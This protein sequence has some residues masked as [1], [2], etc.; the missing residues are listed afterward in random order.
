MS[1]VDK[2]IAALIKSQDYQLWQIVPNL[3]E[4]II[5]IFSETIEAYITCLCDQISRLNIPIS[6]AGL[7]IVYTPMH[8]V[9]LEVVK[10]IA[11]K[12]GIGNL[13][14]VPSQETPDPN[15]PTVK[16]PN[17]EEGLSALKEAVNFAEA[18]GVQIVFANDPDADRFNFAQ[19]SDSEGPWR[20]FTGNEIA[21][22]LADFVWRHRALLYPGYEAFA[23]VNSCVSS[24]LLRSMG[25]SEGFS[26][27]ETLT[28]FKYIANA[29]QRLERES[30]GTT[31]VILA[32]EE[33]IGFMLNT[34]IWE[35]DGL[36]AL[37]F[38]YFIMAEAGTTTMEERLV[39][40]Y[41]KYGY[42][43]SYNS[44]Y[45]CEP[46]SRITT[47]FHQIRTKLGHHGGARADLT[48]PCRHELGDGRQIV[49]IQDYPGANMITL[50]LDDEGLSWITLRASGTEPKIKFYSEQKCVYEVR[51]QA[52]D[53]LMHTVQ[54]ICIW[55]L[56]PETNKLCL[57][58]KA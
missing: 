38:M 53:E 13:C 3:T 7:K 9:G 33:A 40:I 29:A 19:K 16:F 51:Q 27:I 58:N 23:M 25:L 43:A 44:Y 5:D 31:K 1:P 4:S 50:F 6:D 24:K 39:S 49:R 22:I 35:K 41:Q 10:G 47:I 20:V 30:K 21:A 37:L 42:F 46:A 28:G 17:P 18:Q 26:V 32:Y 48:G 55:L 2:E 11:S 54:K 36:S 56:D 8:G 12:L 57:Q 15:F 45:F 52:K 14:T 34:E